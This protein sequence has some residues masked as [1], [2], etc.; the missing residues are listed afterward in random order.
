MDKKRNPVEWAMHYRHLVLLV[1]VICVLFGIYGLDKV[2]K[3][4][5]PNFTIRQGVVVAVYPGATSEE[6]EQQVT[7]PLENYLFTYK[8]VKKEKTKSFSRPGMAIIQVQ[9]NDDIADKGDFWNKVKHGLQI[10]R[11]QLPSGVVG[12]QVND[13]FGDTSSLLITMDSKDKTYREL[14]EYMK[15]LKDSLWQIES[16]GRLTVLGMQQEQISVYLDDNKLTSYGV[17]DATIASRLQQK[18]F[19]TSA[20]QLKN[21][22][23]TAPIIVDHPM[24]M[25]HD[26]ENMI[27]YS[28]NQGNNI[29]L[30]DV[31]RVVREYSQP[32]S[33]VTVND[34]KALVLSVEM[35]PGR[36]ITVMG[37]AISKKMENFKKTLPH[38]VHF[39]T[40]TDQ[41][42]VV[43]DSV[44]DFLEELL[45]AVV[46]VVLVVMILMP[47]RVALV[48][49]GTIP[50]TIFTSLGLFYALDIELNTVTLAALIVTLGIIVDD[51]IVIIDNYV[52]K[53][54]EDMPRWQAAITSATALFKS[55]SSATLA[56]SVTFFPFLMVMT[57]QAYDFL[58]TFPWAISIVLFV[59]MFVAMLIVPFLQFWF[60]RKPV[61]TE[62]PEPQEGEEKK[63]HFS[64]LVLMQKWYDKLI[65]L[66]FRHPYMTIA[67]G[68]LA[69]VGGL[70]LM[71]VLPQRQMPF[72]D[73][74][75]FAVEI[76]L[77]T[78]SSLERTE[79][80]A[81][82]MEHILRRDKR[83]VSVAAFKGMSS[84]RFQ[85]SYAPQFAGP[86]YA[87]FIVNTPDNKTT[88][89]LIKDY[90]DRYADYFPGVR[91]KV[92]R[93]DYSED[94][95]PIEIRLTSGD[96]D[97]LKHDVDAL[98]DTLKKMS[99]LCLVHTDVEGQQFTEK[100]VVDDDLADRLGI[101]HQMLQQTLG[102]RYYGD[103]VKVGDVWQGDY[104]TQIKLK[105][106]H[107]DEG[108]LN[109]LLNEQI[110][111]ADGHSTVP[112]R[113]FAKV[114]PVWQDGEIP[115]RNGLRTIS[116]IA[117]VKTGVN[118]MKATADIMSRLKDFKPSKG[119]NIV[120]GGE[121]ETTNE[122]NPKLVNSV[123]MAAAIIFFIL[124][125]HFKKVSTALLILFALPLCLFGSSMGVL[126]SGVDF[127]M[128]CFLGIISLRGILVRNA[129][130][131]Y[132]YAEE[133]REK[134]HL[135]AHEA[136]LHSAKRRMRPIFLT[137]SAASMGV[138]PMILGGSGLWSPMGNVIFW[139]TLI[140]MLLILT[141]MP[142]SY[143]LA[144]SGSTKKRQANEDLE[145][146]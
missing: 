108:S 36:N 122:N 3:N 84:P 71:G 37:D 127:S 30:K 53:L 75:Q 48:S 85:T 140:T 116:V 16:V 111:T 138:V 145:K 62:L 110:P 59:S 19:V 144:M 22:H 131:M 42:K 18:G 86:N 41:S 104:D 98:S 83:I 72:A 96:W 8:E 58:L 24:N 107:A 39:T 40:V 64:F 11:T 82:S 115:H 21:P 47:M 52:D 32:S 146:E 14:N 5:F 23:Y 114:V 76:T 79:A 60:I 102:M 141:V 10:F 124:L 31:A 50:I 100:L 9:L 113:Q 95:Y 49:A 43:S 129:I 112:L 92:K 13:D 106:I 136:I 25:V 17:S 12:I 35:K 81:D 77:P 7:K 134:E 20:G 132:D 109:D 69:V 97:T 125:M 51:S 101:N 91:V 4:E 70:G 63:K 67:A 74:N 54:G 89:E 88:V 130:I 34:N 99:Q 46:A 27:V 118:G 137:S 143:W 117:D 15:Q 128:T 126:I 56:I 78:G 80:V 87:Q 73:R 93:L 66:C 123:L 135:T 1:A 105:G 26:V 33:L 28:D 44:A 121:Y 103:G 45:I 133:L 90:H 29:R 61:I 119:T 68:V 142:V 120:Y 65:E 94:A 38:D 57:G 6:V 139:G 2:N 55:V